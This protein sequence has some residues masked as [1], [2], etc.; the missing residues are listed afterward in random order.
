MSNT[1]QSVVFLSGSPKVKQ[2]EAV[3]NFL[4]KR[5]AELLADDSLDARVICV[6][7]SL[8]HR[9]TEDAFA[10]VQDADA[11]VVIFP[12]YF[13]CMPAMLTRF[14]QDFVVRYPAASK[15]ANVYAIVNCGFPEPEINLEAMRVVES[16][17]RHTGRTF[18]GGTLVGCGGMLLAAQQAPF[19]KPLFEEIDGLLLRIKKDLGS[20]EPAIPV[21]SN[22]AVKFPRFLYFLAGNSGWH[23]AARKNGLRSNDLKRKPY[24][25]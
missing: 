16:F 15:Q 6:R 13:F 10:A 7:E 19:M 5:G 2:D 8:L 12:L 3:S 23:M 11:I 17:C 1:K 14:L 21:L 9:Q 24:Q 22:I 25:S 18:G 4:A 20:S